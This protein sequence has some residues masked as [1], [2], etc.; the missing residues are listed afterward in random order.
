MANQLAESVVEMGDQVCLDDILMEIFTQTDPKTVAKC[1][2]TSTTWRVRLSSDEFRRD[3][4]IAN[5]GKHHKLLLLIGDQ[6]TY[7]S[8]VSFCL[9]DCLDGGR[10]PAPM[11]KQ[12]GPRGW[13]SVIGS[14][15]GM[16]CVRYS[17]AGFDKGLMVWNPLLR[18]AR[19]LDDPA[20]TLW[21]QAVIGYAF[22]YRAGTENYYVVHISKRYLKNRFLHCNVFNS[23]D[24]L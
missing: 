20:D 17:R 1:R 5:S 18:V 8:R 14:D 15:C 22:G 19:Q 13:W 23:A 3:N 11:L 16:I 4:T 9:V 6:E 10:V 24:G 2:T 12:L 21:K 7:C